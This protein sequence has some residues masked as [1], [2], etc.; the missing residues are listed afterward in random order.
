MKRKLGFS[1][2]FV[3]LF[4]FLFFL[5]LYTFFF[6]DNSSYDFVWNY[7][8]SH[9]IRMGEIPYIDFNMISTPLYNFIMSLGLFIWD[10][11]LMFMIEQALFCTALFYLFFRYLGKKAWLLLP[12]MAFPLFRDFI[13]TYNFLCFFLIVYLLYLE[14]K[15]RKNHFYIGI[16][17]GL[18]VLSKQT[19]GGIVLLL[20][21]FL[22]R[23]GKAILKRIKGVLIPC[24]LF[25]FYLLC[26]KSFSSF[27]DLCFLG[28]F[29]FGSQNGSYFNLPF[30]L[31]LFMIFYLIYY[32]RQT[33]D[34]KVSYII[35]GFFFAFPLFDLYHFKLFIDLFFVFLLKTID[36]SNIEVKFRDAYIRNLSVLLTVILL[37]CCVFVQRTKFDD[38]KFLDFPRFRYYF[39][40]RD[41]KN[42]LFDI[43]EKYLEYPD[44]I[45][46]GYQ[47]M[48]FDLSSDRNITYF[49]VPLKGNYGYRGTSKMISRVKNMHH[50]YFFIDIE[51]FYYYKNNNQLDTRLIQYIIEHSK[52]VDQVSSYYIY[53]KE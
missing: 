42:N 51:R 38:L 1:N 21:L 2:K 52:K 14:D 13:A 39:M 26:T 27:F 6:Y 31:S 23:D 22:L 30:F 7:G 43:R 9:A 8:F 10:D 44:A 5:S 32:Y 40:N 47:G 25:L 36:F 17:L 48:L 50:Q 12:I 35:G 3:F 18:L 4:L 20:N 19:I 45:L 33:K 46:V 16:I 49:D 41:V 15:P 53:Y 29:D 11:F 34:I 24:S 37:L 28:L